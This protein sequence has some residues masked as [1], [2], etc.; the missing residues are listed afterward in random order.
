M[1]INKKNF[2]ECVLDSLEAINWKIK[3][4]DTF[5]IFMLPNF[6]WRPFTPGEAAPPALSTEI[7]VC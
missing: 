5:M 2:Q 3:L 6:N 4:H 7:A 1:K